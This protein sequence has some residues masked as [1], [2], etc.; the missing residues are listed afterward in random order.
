M[1]G[2]AAETG[3]V[4]PVTLTSFVS[5]VL[6]SD[7]VWLSPDQIISASRNSKAIN[8]LTLVKPR[9]SDG[10]C[11]LQKLFELSLFLSF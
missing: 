7:S 1:L 5:D 3:T 10:W 4:A 9:F 8:L 11:Y 2:L 6:Y